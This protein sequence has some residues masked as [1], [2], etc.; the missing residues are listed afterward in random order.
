MLVFVCAALI[1]LPTTTINT[2]TITTTTTATLITRL[3]PFSQT[4]VVPL[5][6]NILRRWLEEEE[7]EEENGEVENERQ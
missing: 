5:R 1:T 3:T 6:N 4:N 2:N 7:E